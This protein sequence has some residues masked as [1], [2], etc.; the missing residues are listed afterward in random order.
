VKN[1]LILIRFGTQQP[2]RKLDNKPTQPSIP[3]ASVNEY[4]LWLRRQRQVADERVGVQLKLRSLEN[5]CHTW[6][7]LRW[8][9]T[10]R[11]YI[12]CVDPI[13]FF[14]TSICLLMSLTISP[15]PGPCVS[16]PC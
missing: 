10:K 11:R 7:L 12:K 14:L 4:Q 6:A 2:V 9:F 15:C 5:T 3:P 16:S 13:K 8:W 1:Q